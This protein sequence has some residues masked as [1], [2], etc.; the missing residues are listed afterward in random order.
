MHPAVW[1]EAAEESGCRKRK[2]N[3]AETPGNMDERE[4]EDSLNIFRSLGL[5]WGPQFP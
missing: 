2:M 5:V 3:E 4:R 1:T